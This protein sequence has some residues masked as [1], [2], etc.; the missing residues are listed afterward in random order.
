MTRRSSSDGIDA[1]FQS[2]LHDLAIG[3]RSSTFSSWMAATS[4]SVASWASSI[5]RARCATT[6][7]GRFIEMAVA[8][9]ANGLV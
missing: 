6:C 8:Q 7:A 5:P 3:E 4:A 9:S 2:V 1:K